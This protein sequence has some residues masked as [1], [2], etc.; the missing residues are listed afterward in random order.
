MWSEPITFKSELPNLKNKEFD[1]LD[2]D[3]LINA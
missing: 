3:S 1:R 2:F